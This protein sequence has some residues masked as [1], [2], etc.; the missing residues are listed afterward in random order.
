MPESGGE[1]LKNHSKRGLMSGRDERVAGRENLL[2]Q[3]MYLERRA[4]GSRRRSVTP[5]TGVQG[6][7]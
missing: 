3:I 1:T 4:E 2:G 7:V 6:G 5:G